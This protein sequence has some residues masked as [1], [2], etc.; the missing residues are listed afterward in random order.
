MM[1]VALICA[2]VQLLKFY[3]RHLCLVTYTYQR[4]QSTASVGETI[5]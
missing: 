1:Q 5:G 4:W 3:R 2:A